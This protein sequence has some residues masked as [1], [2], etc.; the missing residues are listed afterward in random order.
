VWTNRHSTAPSLLLL[1]NRFPLVRRLLGVLVVALGIAGITASVLWRSR[2]VPELVIYPTNL[3]LTQE[4]RGEITQFFD[5]DTASALAVPRVGPLTISRHLRSSPYPGDRDLV[6]VLERLTV[7][8]EGDAEDIEVDQRHQYVM[9]R[10]TL[11]NVDDPRAWAFTQTNVVDRGGTFRLNFPF[12]TATGRAYPVYKDEY[13]VEYEAQPVD[14]TADIPGVTLTGFESNVGPYPLSEAYLDA[15]DEIVALPDALTVDQLRPVLGQRG[16]DIDA[17]VLSLLAVPEAADDLGTLGALIAEPIP[18]RYVGSSSGSDM[19]DTATGAVVEISVVVE[20]VFA[21][22]DPAAL[23]PLVDILSKYG[24]LPAVA[25]ALE[26]LQSF[27]DDPIPVFRTEYAQTEASVTDIAERVRDQRR[28][29]DLVENTI[30][31]VLTVVG[32]AIGLLGL[33]LVFA[34]RRAPRLPPI[35]IDAPIVRPDDVGVTKL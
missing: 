35:D 3:D 27:V 31:L 21:Q 10:T 32:G 23:P 30:P 11:E 6:I 28:R 15:L 8:T 19:V 2:A 7:T 13:E 33:F 16:V 17:T 12:D 18:L 26:G 22:P 1:R 25:D 14:A 24:D 20:D 34:P 4:L 5:A 9:D 29:I